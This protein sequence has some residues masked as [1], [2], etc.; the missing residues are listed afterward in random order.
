MDE[1]THNDF[2]CNNQPQINFDTWNI[3]MY[4]VKKQDPVTYCNHFKTMDR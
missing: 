1:T 3:F 2:V 4:I